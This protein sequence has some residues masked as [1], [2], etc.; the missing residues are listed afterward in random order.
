MKY[1]SPLNFIFSHSFPFNEHN[2]KIVLSWG[3]TSLGGQLKPFYRLNRI[4]ADH[5]SLS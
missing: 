4:F 5:F 1:C 3:A 2:S